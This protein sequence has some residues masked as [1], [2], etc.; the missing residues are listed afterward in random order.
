MKTQIGIYI[1]HILQLFPSQIK[2]FGESLIVPINYKNIKNKKKDFIVF[3]T[4]TQIKKVKKAKVNK[5]KID[6][7]FS[8][9]QFKRTLNYVTKINKKEIAYANVQYRYEQKNNKIKPPKQPEKEIIKKTLKKYNDYKNRQEKPKK[10]KQVIVVK[11]LK[12]YYD[13]LKQNEIS[14]KEKQEFIKKTLKKYNDNK[15]KQETLKKIKKYNNK[16]KQETLKKII[17]PKNGPYFEVLKKDDPN[18]H[19]KTLS[20]NKKTL[21]GHTVNLLQRKYKRKRGE[22]KS[23]FDDIMIPGILL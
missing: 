3:L 1:K 23:I 17:K 14:E 6:L 7:K 22:K 16:N 2:K 9:T 4:K 19:L 8:K 21:D 13:T 18:L 15:D 10:E 11:K 20:K 12:D 5:E